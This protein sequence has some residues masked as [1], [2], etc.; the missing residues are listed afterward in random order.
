LKL[1]PEKCQFFKKSVQYLGHVV[2]EHGVETDPRKISALTTWPKPQN[3]QQLKSF[4]GFSE[5]YRRFIR[6]YSK[7]ARPLNDLT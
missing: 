7:L 6:D 5:Y 1:S 4:L 2:S 3:I